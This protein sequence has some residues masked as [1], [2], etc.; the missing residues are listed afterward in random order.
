M[1]HQEGDT[2]DPHTKG[3]IIKQT[4]LQAITIRKF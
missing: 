2:Y 1:R 3:G 4:S